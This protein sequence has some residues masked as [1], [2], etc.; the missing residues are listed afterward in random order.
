MAAVLVRLK[1]T[2]LV[3]GWR[4]S[5][6]QVVGFAL[7]ALWALGIVVLVVAGAVA[8]SFAD[9][10]AAR[11]GLVLIGAPAVLGWWIIPVVAQGLDSTLD[12]RR[13]QPLGLDPR[14]LVVGL[15]LAT[16]VGVPGATTAASALASALVW[17]DEPLAALVG[18]VGGVLG[19]ALCVVGARAVVAVLAPL[20]ERRRFRE[21]VTALVVLPLAL[22]PLISPI[23][24]RGV[25]GSLL[26]STAGV[27]AWTP[28]GAPWALGA[29]V[30]EGLWWSLLGRTAICVVTLLVGL[31]VWAS[32]MERA[33]VSPPARTAATRTHGYGWFDRLPSSPVGVVAARCLTYWQ[34][35]PRY[36]GSLLY[37]PFLPIPFLVLGGGLHDNDA[38]L[39]VGPV[40]AFA[41]AFAIS[42]DLAYDST[43]WW[44]HVASGLA[45][46]A[47]R[48]GRVVSASLLAAPVVLAFTLASVAVSGRWD[49]LVAVLGLDLG[50]M[51][52]TLGTST[53]MAVRYLYPVPLPGQSMFATPS[54]GGSGVIVGQMIGFAASF[55]LSLPAVALFLL[56][57][58]SGS[59]AAGL[60]TLVVGVSVG[61][62]VLRQ[63]LRTSGAHLDRRGPDIL[64]RLVAQG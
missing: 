34:R 21:V 11:T 24:D 41:L 2:L 44:L 25:S 9:P 23:L 14:S 13:F 1:L 15:A 36:A 62:L 37:I 7:F 59:A 12:A 6:W 58:A 18:L 48:T 53:V 8:A 49:L 64:Q 51:L 43:A 10:G 20:S 30:A 55:A 35:D 46:Q 56:A 22:L 63:A 26:E 17:W 27:V 60:A 5:P 31:R 33:L 54:G 57:W 16:L 3:N 47:D 42:A 28:A 61:A 38:L 4:R 40:V 45:G 32:A 52:V 29:D 39:A 50:V 19:L